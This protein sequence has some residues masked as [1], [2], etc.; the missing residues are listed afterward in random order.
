LNR[1][2]PAAEIGPYVDQLARRIASFPPEAV[3]MAK[4]AVNSA[5]KPLKEGLQDESYLFQCLVRTDSGRRNMTRFLEIGGQ[6]RDG[7]LR[8]AE[9]SA[10]LGQA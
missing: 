9:L 8:V 6:T 5:T 2:L 7:E 1:A 10:E 3:R 4:E